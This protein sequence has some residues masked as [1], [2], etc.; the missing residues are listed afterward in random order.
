MPNNHDRV[1]RKHIA[2]ALVPYRAGPLRLE[3]GSP[4]RRSLRSET[5][6]CVGRHREWPGSEQIPTAGLLVG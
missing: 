5:A 1:P 3:I 2:A 4:H 6:R